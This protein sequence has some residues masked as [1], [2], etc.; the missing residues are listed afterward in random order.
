MSAVRV[1]GNQHRKNAITSNAKERDILLSRSNFLRRFL[2]KC[3]NSSSGV[4][5]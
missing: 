3:I 1:Y 4:E 2:S 5:I